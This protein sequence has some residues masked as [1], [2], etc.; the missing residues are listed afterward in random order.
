MMVRLFCSGCWYF[1]L[2]SNLG[3]TNSKRDD[4]HHDVDPF[5]LV[6]HFAKNRHLHEL[7]CFEKITGGDD[8][9]FR[10]DPAFNIL[11]DCFTDA[12]T[13][14]WWTRFWCVQESIL[15]PSATVVLGHWRVPWKTVKNCE[16]NYKYH[17]SKCCALSCG[18]MPVDY[19]FYAD[20]TIVSTHVDSH[21]NTSLIPCLS[22]DLDRLLRS[23]R[24]KTCQ[25]PR[26]KV[27]GILGL[28]DTAVY[29][30]LTVNYSLDIRTVYLS[31]ME[32]MLHQ[33]SRLGD[34]RCL[35][36][37]G[38][39]SAHH[40]LPSWVRD[41]EICPDLSSLHYE[42]MRYSLYDLYHAAGDS[43]AKIIILDKRFMLVRGCVVDKIEGVG[44]AVTSRDWSHI[45]V[46]LENWAEL[47]GID[48]SKDLHDG[49]IFESRQILFWRTL[50]G[51]IVSDDG[52]E[53][54]RITREDL[55]SF[56]TWVLT[57]QNAIRTQVL[58]P[59]DR[60]LKSLVVA[61]FGRVMFRTK[62]GYVGLC[63][64]NCRLDDEIWVLQGGKVPFLL[65]LCGQGYQSSTGNSSQYIF[66]GEGYMHSFMDGEAM[67]GSG[68][69][70]K[71]VVLR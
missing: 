19:T 37:L 14:P 48:L 36:G 22:D 53:A 57:M 58:P 17:V 25:N 34:L 70:I 29:G 10:Y 13:K 26:D 11:W 8:Y 67:Q 18:S 3:Y 51:D 39:N 60:Y 31:I 7:S 61:T 32:A 30:D 55:R 12:V 52:E 6:R 49:H 63:F 62:H 38:F 65:R 59:T 21:G 35:T 33:V 1:L 28:V 56:K 15:S 2:I 16:I 45:C 64:P 71:E 5:A 42:M 43:T 66:L 41:F 4:I 50:L 44:E 27:Y 54:Q 40:D 47:A 9:S 46:I 23:F 20:L 24:Y 68:S 69:C